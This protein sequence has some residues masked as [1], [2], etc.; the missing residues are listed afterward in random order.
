[1][2]KKSV[3]C[4]TAQNL[5]GFFLGRF[6]SS[7]AF[8]LSF[9]LCSSASSN[10]LLFSS[11]PSTSVNASNF[12]FSFTSATGPAALFLAPLRVLS[13]RFCQ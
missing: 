8:S 10:L 9:L 2:T 12:F 13:G 5:L 1:M 6:S 4:D 3:C 11:S 7:L